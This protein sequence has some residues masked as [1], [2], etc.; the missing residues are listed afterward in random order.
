MLNAPPRAMTGPRLASCASR[1][2]FAVFI[3]CQMPVK[4]G[5]PSAV[6]GSAVFR[7]CPDT[8]RTV[9]ARNA[10]ARAATATRIAIPCRIR[11]LTPTEG[12][13]DSCGDRH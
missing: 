7:P 12:G 6:R 8:V 9:P 5:L 3:A 1:F 2:Q 13:T 4:S 10:A 11:I